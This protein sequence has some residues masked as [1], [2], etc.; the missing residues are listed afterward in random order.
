MGIASQAAQSAVSVSDREK[1]TTAMEKE[2]ILETLK[3][4]FLFNFRTGNVMVDTV[5]TGLI[6]M[7]ST[8]L[9]N[10]GS[11]LCKNLDY[12]HWLRWYRVKDRAQITMLDCLTAEISELSEVPIQEPENVCY[13]YN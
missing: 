6:I 2:Q 5:V 7:F 9:F 13:D 3:S 4:S 11:D 12:K 1:G 8:Y 10:L